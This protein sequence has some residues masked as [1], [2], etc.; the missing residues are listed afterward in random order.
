MAFMGV[1][2]EHQARSARDTLAGGHGGQLDLSLDHHDPGALVNFMLLEAF[3]GR[4]MQQD[5][6]CIIGSRKNVRPVWLH[7]DGPQIPIPHSGLLTH[8]I[9]GPYWSGVEARP[10][11]V[12]AAT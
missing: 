6:T 7:I 10:R 2:L 11:G 1:E 12:S 8:R 4:E 9:D 5:R 3:A